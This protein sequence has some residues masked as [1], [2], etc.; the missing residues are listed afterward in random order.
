MRYIS[1]NEK[2]ERW[3]K[4]LYAGSEESLFYPYGKQFAI[5]VYEKR[6]YQKAGIYLIPCNIANEYL[7]DFNDTITEAGITH[8]YITYKGEGLENMMEFF[9]SKDWI[10][11]TDRKMRSWHGDLEDAVYVTRSKEYSRVLR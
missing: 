6:T 9:G 10:V 7:E 5:L 1:K 3:S 4:E 2:M 8:F 11:K